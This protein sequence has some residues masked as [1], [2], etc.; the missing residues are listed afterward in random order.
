MQDKI[1]ELNDYRLLGRS[2]LRV[3]PLCLGTMTFGSDWGWGSDEKDSRAI[4]DKYL[5]LGGNFL[6]TANI[7]TNGTSEEFCG[8]FMKGKRDKIVLATKFTMGFEPGDPN[9]T[10]NGRKTM[11]QA[12]E[13]S[14]RRLDTDVID[15][16][17]VHA[18]D[19]I[20]PIEELLRG[21]DDLVRQGK[22]HYVGFSDFPAWKLAEA[23]TMALLRGYE[24]IIGLQIEHSLIERTVERELI[25]AARHFGMAVLPWSPL[26]GGVLAGKYAKEDVTKAKENPDKNPGAGERPVTERLTERNLAIAEVVKEVAREVGA[27]ASQVALRWLVDQ[28]YV[29]I[30]IIGARTMKHLEDNLGALSV[31]FTEAQLEKLNEASQIEPGFPQGFL[32]QI[33]DRIIKAGNKIYDF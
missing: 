25:P 3:S 2:G 15:L 16:L 23:Q 21:F 28:P 12:V 26:G 20:T 27:T 14:L 30:P 32:A 18:W 7:Y 33:G 24:P 22:V 1:R 8:K 13:A 31:T 11:R 19:G 10:G 9:L 5:D 4:F 6:D 17:Y 29:S